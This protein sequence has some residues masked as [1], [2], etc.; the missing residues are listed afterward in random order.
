[1]EIRGI[2]VMPILQKLYDL[3]DRWGTWYKGFDN[4]VTDVMPAGTTELRARAVMK[5]LGREGF[6]AGC[7]CG[8]RGDYEL[9]RKGYD[10]CL[11]K[12]A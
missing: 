1:M 9:L 4:S 2:P 10:L 5:I 6:I 12:S 3:D 7:H 11:N 8:C